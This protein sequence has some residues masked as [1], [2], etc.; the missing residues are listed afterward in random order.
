MYQKAL[1]FARGK[2]ISLNPLNDF[3]AFDPTERD[4]TWVCVI[5]TA[6]VSGYGIFALVLLYCFVLL[7]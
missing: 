5:L 3:A 1:V 7:L 4:K 2:V 6:A